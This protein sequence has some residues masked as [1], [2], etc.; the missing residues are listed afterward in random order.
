[1]F[2]DTIRV[3][4][5]QLLAKHHIAE[6]IAACVKYTRD[7]NPWASQERIHPILK[8]LV[9]YGANAQTVI[10]HLRETAAMFDAG[11]KDFPKNLSKQKAEALREAIAKIEASQDKPELNHIR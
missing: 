9:T 6:G 2:A 3:E 8:T 1:M 10:P 4:G 5:L 7:Q 11:E